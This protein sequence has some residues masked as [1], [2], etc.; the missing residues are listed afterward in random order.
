MIYQEDLLISMHKSFKALVDTCN[1]M[2]L[3]DYH[4]AAP[5]KLYKLTYLL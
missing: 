5:I 2:L 3:R 4:A 1:K